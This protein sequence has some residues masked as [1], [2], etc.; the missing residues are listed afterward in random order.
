M[1]DFERTGH[2]PELQDFVLLEVDILTRLTQGLTANKRYKLYHALLSPNSF[3]KV[4][5]TDPNLEFTKAIQSANIIRQIVQ[6][7]ITGPSFQNYLWGLLLISLFRVLSLDRHPTQDGA[8]Q[9][10]QIALLFASLV[11]HRIENGYGS[12]WDPRTAHGHQLEE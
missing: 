1:I 4:T 9:N 5:I 3:Q 12:R 10:K 2:G 7:K 11:C 6:T 8:D